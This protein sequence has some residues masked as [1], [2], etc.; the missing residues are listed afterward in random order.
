MTDLLETQ[1]QL[2]LEMHMTGIEG[3]RK[4]VRTRRLVCWP[5]NAEILLKILE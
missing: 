5:Q 1:K 3:Y 2:E 4:K